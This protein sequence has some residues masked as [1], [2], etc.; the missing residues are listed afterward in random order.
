MKKQIIFYSVFLGSLINSSLISSPDLFIN[1]SCHQTCKK[2]Q[3]FFHMRAFSSSSIREIEMLKTMYMNDKPNQH[4]WRKTFAS[5]L[6]Y[7]VNFGCGDGCSNNLGS[8]PFWSGTNSMTYGTNDGESDV[9]GY[10]FGMGELSDQGVI[11]LNVDIMQVACDMIFHATHRKGHHGFYCTIRAPLGAMTVQTNF[12]ED[13]ASLN[14]TAEETLNATWLSYPSAKDRYQTLTEAFQ[15]GVVSE[16]NSPLFIHSGTHRPF[17]L[18]KS[19]F[20][21]FRMTAIRLADL[22]ASFGYTFYADNDDNFVNLGAKFLAPTGNVPTGRYVLEPVF[23]HASMW[24][25][26][27]ELLGHYKLWE[28]ARKDRGL[29]FWVMSDAMHLCSGRK[30]NFRTFD[31]KLNGLGSKYLLVQ[32]YFPS[33]PSSTNSTGAIPSY[34][35]QAAN[36]T[37]MPVISGFNLEST[38]AVLFD[39]HERNWNFAIGSEFWYRSKENLS[40]DAAHLLDVETVTLHEYVVLGRQV[41]DDARSFMLDPNQ[42]IL[43]LHLCEPLATINKSIA[44]VNGV[45]TPPAALTYP[46][47]I[48]EGVED[49]RLAG[50]RIPKDMN[51]ALDVPGAAAE[52]AMTAKLSGQFGY[53]W[54]EYRLTPNLAFLGNVEW[55][56]GGGNAMINTY[57]VGVQGSLN[58]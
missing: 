13:V 18:D 19:R 10:Q 7:M 24:G 14:V 50:S 41:S 38:V 8:L 6:E 57:S 54:K 32:K 36:I 51:E 58:F 52:Q 37:T 23:G 33:T 2:S 26:G 15:T 1:S 56:L 40:I 12:K 29:D 5:A 11:K 27:I 30:P 44:R 49:A 16:G 9:D 47:T 21:G 28:D 31:L 35:T 46:V 39:F 45:G 25:V 42:D 43:S 3:S 48:P 53:T 22:C 20:A 55:A 34:I 17:A 4:G